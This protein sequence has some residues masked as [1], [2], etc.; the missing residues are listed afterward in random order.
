MQTNDKTIQPEDENDSDSD[1][2]DSIIEQYENVKV[3]DGD[4]ASRATRTSFDAV[5]KELNAYKSRAFTKAEIKMHPLEFWS[6]Q[7]DAFPILRLV[8]RKVFGVPNS[9]GVTENDVGCAGRMRTSARTR[10]KGTHVDQAQVVSR[11]QDLIRLDQIPSLSAEE[12]SKKLPKNPEI[13]RELSTGVGYYQTW[14][15]ALELHFPMGLDD[16][17]EEYLEDV[18]D[19]AHVDDNNDENNDN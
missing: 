10:L 1:S 14:F 12:V 5:N 18:L 15:N 11:N 13:S 19:D 8:V 16:E 2:D 17:T 6:M 7:E 3:V 9:S 4:E